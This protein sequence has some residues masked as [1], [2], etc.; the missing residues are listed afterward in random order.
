MECPPCPLELKVD[1]ASVM[2]PVNC[3][4][5]YNG[6]QVN[7]D[8]DSGECDQDGV[9][10]GITT[11]DINKSMYLD[12]VH[13][14]QVFALIKVRRLYHIEHPASRCR[15]AFSHRISTS[16]CH[17][18]LP[19]RVA[20]SHS[21]IALPHRVATSRCHIALPHRIAT[22][23]CHIA[24]PPQFWEYALLG[25]CFAFFFVA[26]SFVQV[27]IGGGRTGARAWIMRL[28]EVGV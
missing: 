17:S 8:A 19:H 25:D 2:N 11:F 16:Y 13:V 6:F 20:T 23:R 18:V 10:D 5:P 15:V 26:I 27:R 9:V 22:S 24:L 21:H 3:K 28:G 12:S 1:A 7:F 14:P 4:V